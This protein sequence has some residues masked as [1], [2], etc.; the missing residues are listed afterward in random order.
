MPCGEEVHSLDPKI[1]GDVCWGCVVGKKEEK[2]GQDEELMERE[3]RRLETKA[4][5]VVCMLLNA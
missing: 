2:R 1:R 3:T 4:G 5:K